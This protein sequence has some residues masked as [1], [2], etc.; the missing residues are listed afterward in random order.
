M[1]SKEYMKFRIPDKDAEKLKKL[2]TPK[3]L[4][5][6]VRIPYSDILSYLFGG[7]ILN[8]KDIGWVTFNFYSPEKADGLEAFLQPVTIPSVE[9]PKINRIVAKADSEKNFRQLGAIFRFI[10][11]FIFAAIII[12]EF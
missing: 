1:F 7:K 2:A 11:L 3:E 4:S 6:P 12:G 9:N 5:I 8:I 10:I